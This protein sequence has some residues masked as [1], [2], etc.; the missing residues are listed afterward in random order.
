MTTRFRIIRVCKGESMSAI[1]QDVARYDL[2]A[3]AIALKERGYEVDDKEV[4]LLAKKDGIEVTVYMNGR[5]MI[6]PMK[7]REM[8]KNLA[9][10]LY[11]ILVMEREE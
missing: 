9:E 10:N 1:P 8:A 3:S 4:M 7:D 11:S 5:L 6:S 2:E